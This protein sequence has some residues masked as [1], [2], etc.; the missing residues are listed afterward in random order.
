M[1]RTVIL[2]LAFLALPAPAFA[3]DHDGPAVTIDNAAFATPHLD[4]LAGDT[5][6]WHNASFRAH[7][8]NAADGSFVSPRLLASSMFIHR[9]DTPGDFAYYCQLHPSM[10]GDV[11]VHR[12]LLNPATQPGAPGKPYV[13]TGRAAL[14]EGAKVA[15]EPAGV[16]ATVA[17]GGTFSATVTPTA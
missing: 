5:V 9:F 3:M 14:P 17:A 15:I 7:N 6:T 10:R 11:A 16:T 12:V 8:V 2:L 4:V 1:R 13:L